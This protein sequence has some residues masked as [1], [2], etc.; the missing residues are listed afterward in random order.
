M[1]LVPVVL[2]L[3]VRELA[4]RDFAVLGLAE[5]DAVRVG[6]QT[7]SHMGAGFG[8]RENNGESALRPAPHCFFVFTPN[9]QAARRMLCNQRESRE[10]QAKLQVCWLVHYSRE[11]LCKTFSFPAELRRE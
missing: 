3:V 8:W 7:L 1:G 6:M 2:G 9:R 11:W 10:S 5:L 4:V